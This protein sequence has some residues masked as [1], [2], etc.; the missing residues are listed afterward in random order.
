MKFD[1]QQKQIYFYLQDSYKY[2]DRKKKKKEASGRRVST[3]SITYRVLTQKEFY[4]LF[5]DIRI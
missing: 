1:S 3:F 2:A 5:N 4:K